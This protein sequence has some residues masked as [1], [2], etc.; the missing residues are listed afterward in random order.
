MG[1]ELVF[2][3]S[4]R[5]TAIRIDALGSRRGPPAEARLLYRVLADPM[6]DRPGLAIDN[7]HPGAEKQPA[8]SS[9]PQSYPPPVA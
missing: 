5:L 4:G 6:P 7:P 1:D 2:V 9:G 8:E 3:I